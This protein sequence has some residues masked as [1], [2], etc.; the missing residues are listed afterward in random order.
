M[1]SPKNAYFPTKFLERILLNYF[2]LYYF[3]I[4]LCVDPQDMSVNSLS[5]VAVT[6]SRSSL[7]AAVGQRQQVA[8]GWIN[9]YPLSS[10]MSTISKKSGKTHTVCGIQ[11]SYA[12]TDRVLLRMSK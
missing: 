9:T 8:Q 12:G 10:G 6:D 7:D 2:L 11:M 1:Q 5:V 3:Y 4:F